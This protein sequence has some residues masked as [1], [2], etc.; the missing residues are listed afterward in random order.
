MNHFRNRNT[1]PIYIVIIIL[2]TN[3][4][5]QNSVKNE[6]W[7]KEIQVLM[8]FRGEEV[9]GVMGVKTFGALKDFATKHDLTDVVMRG[10]FEDMGY[11]GFEQYLIKYHAYWIRELKN[12]RVIDDVKNKEYIR[13]AEETLYTFDIA[14]QNARLE[15]ERLEGAKTKARRLAQ[16]RE[17]SEKW[18]IEKKETQRLTTDLEQAIMIAEV[19]AEKWFYERLRAQRLTAEREQLERLNSRKAEAKRLTYELEDIIS[20]ASGE[21]DRL[22]DENTKMKTLIVNSENTETMAEELLNTLTQ[23]KDNL[24]D[25]QTQIQALS[26]RNDTLE[27]MMQNMKLELEDMLGV[28]KKPWFLFW[29]NISG[30]GEDSQ[31]KYYTKGTKKPWW[32]FWGKKEVAKVDTQKQV[33][34]HKWYHDFGV[35]I[36]NNNIIKSGV[37]PTF[38][39]DLRYHT[40]LKTKLFNKEMN[41]D[42]SLEYSPSFSYELSTTSLFSLSMLN[43]IP[44]KWN[45]AISLKLGWSKLLEF[46]T[47]NCIYMAPEL[48]YA[49]PLQYRFVST[50]LFLSPQ[51]MFPIGGE[52]ETTMTYLNTGIRIVLD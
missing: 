21:I 7:G 36:N 13:Q 51:I 15:A 22:V 25:A 38:A 6:I 52:G 23:T 50:S 12:Q 11:W 43:T 4:Y 10:T 34:N 46:D 28:P 3:L 1:I 32:K 37:D 49:I 40:P 48:T 17:E 42:I 30:S 35:H 18:Q 29:K 19:E 9:D 20:S 5:S 39:F 45:I 31:K 33:D 16:E 2:T 26:V 14:I 41:W 47:S 44:M 27:I 8:G 24:T